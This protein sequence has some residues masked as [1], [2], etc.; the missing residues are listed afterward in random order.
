MLEV[1]SRSIYESA[2]CKFILGS[3]VK[4]LAKMAVVVAQLAK[5]SLPIPEVRS[6]NPIIGEVFIEKC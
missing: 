2:N 4:K 5:Q 3:N 1:E 6:S